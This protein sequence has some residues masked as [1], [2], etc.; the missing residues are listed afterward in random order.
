MSSRPPRD[1]VLRTASPLTGSH[2]VPGDKSVSHRA[3]M[4]AGFASGTTRI[5]G[6]AVNEDCLSTLACIEALGASVVRDGDAVTITAGGRASIVAP[7]EPLDAG[8]SGTTMRLLSGLLAGSD[9][10]VTIVGDASLST[11]PMRRI[12]TPLGEMGATVDTTE[13]HP[14]IRVRGRA[15]LTAVDVRPDPPSAQVKSAVLFAGLRAGGR[16]RV[17]ERIRTR[18]HTERLLGAF[19]ASAGTDADG[20]W[21]A[22]P[23]ELRSAEVAVPGDVSSAAFLAV[24]ALLVEGS[25]VTIR[26]VGLNPTRTRV[27]DVL[28]GLG[29]PIEIVRRVDAAEPYGD[30]RVRYTDRL[31]PADGSRLVLGPDVVAE[32]IDEVPILAALATRTTGG[33]RFDGAGE[34]RRKESDRIAAMQEGIARMG[35]DVESTPDSLS[36]AGRTRLSGAHVRSWGDH[37]IAM[38]LACLAAASEGE[39]VIEDAGVASVSFPGFFDALP[40]ESFEWRADARCER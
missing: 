34:L 16:T 8:N 7:A 4:L 40:G 28:A 20:S 37:R 22:G 13:G 35:G 5:S 23:A 10:D 31:G 9:V 18:D 24:M 36:V 38:S 33:I 17:R 1:A 12:A 11:R 21:V 27:L 3:A 39:T 29:A 30:V 25:D 14:P 2:R 26:D 32:L 6:Y 15:S 19:G